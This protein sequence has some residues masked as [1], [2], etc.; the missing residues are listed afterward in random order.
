VYGL[1]LDV[2]ADGSSAVTFDDSGSAVFVNGVWINTATDLYTGLDADGHERVLVHFNERTTNADGSTTITALRYEDVTGVNP[3]V[4]LGQVS[5]AAVD[6]EPAT[7]VSGVS[8]VEGVRVT[9]ADGTVLINGEPQVT[10]AGTTATASTVTA[11][12]FP[13][14][15]TDV[16]VGAADGGGATASIGQFTQIP[17]TSSIGEYLWSALRVYGLHLEVAAD[18]SSAVSFD[19]SASA[20][21]VNGVWINTATDLYTG[22]DPSGVERVRVHFNER[23]TNT[24]GSTTIT[25]LRYEDLTGANPDVSL[26]RVVVMPAAIPEVPGDPEVPS[27]PGAPAL[28]QWYAYGVLATGP[29]PVNAAPLAEGA[30]E[31]DKTGDA[32]DGA[33]GQVAAEGVTVSAA[34]TAASADAASVSLYPNTRAAVSLANLRVAVDDDG[35]TVTSDG[36]T[37]AGTAVPAGEITA[38][39]VF[40]LEGTA[41]RV[42]LNEQI[43]VDGNLT[44]LGL[45]FTDVSGLATDGCGS[46]GPD[47]PNGSD[48][49]DRPEGPHEPRSGLPNKAG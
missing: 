12:G 1:H 34:R 22:V 49:P 37:V 4:S 23:I 16:T 33:T 47:R 29:S 5:V 19:N 25:A 38:N 31:E 36:G 39:T 6:T 35:T 2:A 48:R 42:V 14:V 45:H 44:V 32:S 20:V 17:D 7:P 28:P 40:S 3:D 46:G 10:E 41:V 8:L 18:G 27:V 26:G 13:S 30:A 11:V 24:D 15:A 21:F 9:A 43:K